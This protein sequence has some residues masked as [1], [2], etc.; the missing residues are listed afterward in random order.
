MKDQL[1]VE[2]NR[3][4]ET[5][6]YQH[7]RLSSLWELSAE[8]TDISP[9]LYGGGGSTYALRRIGSDLLCF[10]LL[11]LQIILIYRDTETLSLFLQK[12]LFLFHLR[13]SSSKNLL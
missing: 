8:L 10:W 3:Q 5:S 9:T 4:R 12:L 1:K 2:L 13:D 6:F 11:V 7:A